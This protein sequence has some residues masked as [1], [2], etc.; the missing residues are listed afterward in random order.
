M[1]VHL[2]RFNSVKLQTLYILGAVPE[3]MLMFLIL[4]NLQNPLPSRLA[5]PQLLLLI[6]STFFVGVFY[7]VFA[8]FTFKPKRIF[9]PI[10]LQILVWSYVALSDLVLVSM[11]V[12]SGSSATAGLQFIVASWSG[13]IAVV[14]AFSVMLTFG[15][16]FAVTTLVG[17]NGMDSDVTRT[18]WHL[19]SQYDAIMKS[20]KEDISL[21]KILRLEQPVKREGFE[22]FQTSSDKA[23]QVIVMVAPSSPSGTDVVFL[24]YDKVAESILTSPIATELSEILHTHLLKLANPTDLPL[25]SPLIA[26]GLKIALRPTVPRLIVWSGTVKRW[27]GVSIGIIVLV[28]FSYMAWAW[29]GV[30]SE[31]FVLT[32]AG[33]AVLNLVWTL[34]PEVSKRSQA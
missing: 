1:A 27:Q 18:G 5:G 8:S 23:T 32:M 9:S 3:S 2:P 34:A 22:M 7:C 15:Q 10:P 6:L 24:C 4:K 16:F 26:L 30:G 25:T 20:L 33:F 14:G 29:F 19:A 13:D 17:L 11:Q 31:E 12:P 28:L 21:L